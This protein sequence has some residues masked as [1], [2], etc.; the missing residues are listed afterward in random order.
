[1]NEHFQQSLS[2][3]AIGERV[4]WDEMIK[5]PKTRSVVDVRDDK[6]FRS[7]DVDFLWELLDR[8]FWWVEVKSDTMAHRT[9]NIVFELSTSGNVGCF[10][11]TRAR[12]I[13]YYI[14]SA[15][16]M[17]WIDVKE[18]KKFVESNKDNLRLMDMGDNAKGYLVP[19]ESLKGSTVIINETLVNEKE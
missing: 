8:Q 15:H 11:K 1:M 5:N 9:G 4:A 14:I 12:V 19:I 16:K 17:I 3:G 2:D 18:Y 6:F 10:Q 13:A 7:I